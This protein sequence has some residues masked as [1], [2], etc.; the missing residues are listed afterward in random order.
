M[1]LYIGEYTVCINHGFVNLTASSQTLPSRSK[2]TDCDCETYD[3]AKVVFLESC[4]YHLWEEIQT[5]IANVVGVEVARRCVDGSGD[6][7]GEYKN[8]GTSGSEG[9]VTENGS[10]VEESGNES[11]A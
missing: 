9:E 2:Q 1:L 3:Q 8:D 4:Q 10:H 6:Q 11:H 5:L 7:Q